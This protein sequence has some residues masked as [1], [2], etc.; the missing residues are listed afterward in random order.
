MNR[1]WNYEDSG[2]CYEEVLLCVW[3]YKGL[4][5]VIYMSCCYNVM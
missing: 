2:F 5:L 4:R 3:M 1:I